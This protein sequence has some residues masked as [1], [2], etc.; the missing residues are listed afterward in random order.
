MNYGEQEI[1][2][3]VHQQNENNLLLKCIHA[4]LANFFGKCEPQKITV[5]QQ[6]LLLE[7]ATC[8]LIRRHTWLSHVFLQSICN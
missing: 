3:L 8:L 1:F 2:F 6:E 7:L 5:S 4:F